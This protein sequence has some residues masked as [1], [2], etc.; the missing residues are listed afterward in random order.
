MKVLVTGGAGYIG[1]HCCKALAAAGHQPV[2]FDNLSTG[3]RSLIRYGD[4][5][6]GDLGDV[7]AIRR[8]IFEHRPEA[9]I[10]FA[11]S[12]YVGVSMREPR[13]YY[14]N[15]VVAMVNLL[16]AMIEAD[17]RRLV[18]SSSCATYGQPETVPIRE[19]TPQA[20]IN[21]Y[22]ETKLICEQ[23]AR[24]VCAAEDFSCTALR[25][26]NA[27][28]ADRDGELGELHDPET[29]L[30]PL[31]LQAIAD[32]EKPFTIFGNDYPTP[33]GTCI[34]DYLHVEDLAS[35]H[36]LALEKPAAGFRAFNLGT[37]N[38]YSVRQVV[39]AAESATGRRLQAGLE[40]RRPGD[41]PELV[42]D[43]SLVRSE[44]G[45]SPQVSDLP[46][47]LDTAWKWHLKQ[48]A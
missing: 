42:A 46:T 26:F 24:A 40:D 2:V 14:R 41:P 9:V 27:A 38:G 47:I 11:A 23:M 13:L 20:P 45:W 8:A 44:L 18:F 29:H 21:P 31:V 22:G 28:G 16:D 33:D 25:Y 7:S 10:H 19:T 15:N 39:E 17:V 3:H 12:A 30:I 34:R 6:H 5:F 4:F 35:A 48:T 1:S 36:L 43:A 32:P 37:G